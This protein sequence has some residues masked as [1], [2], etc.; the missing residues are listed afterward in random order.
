MWK[1]GFLCDY[2]ET[3]LENAMTPAAELRHIYHLRALVY[4]F[5][6][7]LKF[8][9]ETLHSTVLFARRIDWF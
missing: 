9:I 4:S 1:T 8:R 5:I 7:D 6:D 2:L 3:V